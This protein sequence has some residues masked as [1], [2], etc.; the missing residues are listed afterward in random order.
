MIPH[1]RTHSCAFEKFGGTFQLSWRRV[2]LSSER[3]MILFCQTDGSNDH[4]PY[5][6]HFFHKR[7]IMNH[8]EFLM[9]LV[10]V[11][12]DGWGGVKQQHVDRKCFSWGFPQCADLRARE[13]YSVEFNVMRFN[14]VILEHR[15]LR[16]VL[17]FEG[18]IPIKFAE[19]YHLTHN[20]LFII[21][22]FFALTTL[23]HHQWNKQPTNQETSERGRGWPWRTFEV[24]IPQTLNPCAWAHAQWLCGVLKSDP[25][26]TDRKQTKTWLNRW[27]IVTKVLSIPPSRAS[28]VQSDVSTSWLVKNK[29]YLHHPC[30]QCTARFVRMMRSSTAIACLRWRPRAGSL[31]APCV[32]AVGGSVDFG[33]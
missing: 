18:R 20:F 23:T 16:L 8:V 21:H 6:T 19:N 27:K 15:E 9:I 4:V 5:T 28:T 25:E 11:R 31:P 22:W 3:D 29:R 26:G 10:F 1:L 12:A 24:V 17:I 2:P 14:S 7:L 13:R 30:D 33:F 32:G